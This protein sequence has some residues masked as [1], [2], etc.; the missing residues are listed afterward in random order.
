MI[1]TFIII[2]T[3]HLF[4]FQWRSES[5]DLVGTYPFAMPF[6]VHDKVVLILVV[7]PCI[8]DQEPSP[9]TPSDLTDNYIY[10]H[11]NSILGN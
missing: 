10:I 1:G 7:L 6:K 5:W 9:W 8:L 4:Y 3:F 2:S 11:D